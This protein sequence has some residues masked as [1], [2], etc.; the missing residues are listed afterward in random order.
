VQI[1]Y[2]NAFRGV[3]YAVGEYHYCNW[4]LLFNRDGN[5]KIFLDTKFEHKFEQTWMSFVME[6]MR[7]GKIKAGCLLGSGITHRR[8]FHYPKEIRRENEHYTN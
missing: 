1:S 2:T 3:P 7:D 6:L 5:R 8:D 4:P